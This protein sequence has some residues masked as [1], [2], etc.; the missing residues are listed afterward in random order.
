MS[1][2]EKLQKFIQK[3]SNLIFQT[4]KVATHSKEQ[5]KRRIMTIAQKTKKL[6]KVK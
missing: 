6:F 1:I 2:I 4:Q 5:N 3:V